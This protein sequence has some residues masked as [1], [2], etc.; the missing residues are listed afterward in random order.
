M[1]GDDNDATIA[2]LRA[3]SDAQF[4]RLDAAND[5]LIFEAGRLSALLDAAEATLDEGLALLARWR[6]ERTAA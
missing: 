6:A 3:A 4:D 1:P 2:A 5:R